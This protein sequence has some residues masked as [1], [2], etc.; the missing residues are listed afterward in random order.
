MID[1]YVLI[2]NADYNRFKTLISECFEDNS[3]E[4]FETYINAISNSSA[5]FPYLCMALYQNITLLY[6]EMPNI[7]YRIFEPILDKTYGHQQLH[8]KPLLQNSLNHRLAINENTWGNVELNLLLIQLKYSILFSKSKLIK[9][10]IDLIKSPS[11]YQNSFL[12]TM[13]HDSIFDIKNAIIAGNQNEAPKFYKCPKGHPY[14][15]FDCG[16]PWVVHTCKECGAQ[17]VGKNHVLL[18]DNEEMSIVD[19]TKRGYC[20][21]DSASMKDEPTT[22]RSLNSTQFSLVRFFLHACLY[23]SIDQNEEV[24]LDV[25]I[26]I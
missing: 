25:R 4:K 12:P 26:Y 10:F 5:F 7:P 20:L 11:R 6:R 22:E 18:T 21:K 9:P 15:L 19:N 24:C 23:F 14:V 3:A 17:I 16:R 1:R 13:P 2:E 8:W